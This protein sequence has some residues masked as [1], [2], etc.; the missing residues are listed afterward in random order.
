MH[1]PLAGYVTSEFSPTRRHPVT[2]KVTQHWGIDIASGTGKGTVRAAYAGRVE[3]AG[4]GKLA[5]RS[6]QGVGIRNPDGEFQFYNHLQAI[7]V[8]VGDWVTA[9][10]II[11]IEGATGNVTGP[12]LHFECHY[13]GSNKDNGYSLVRNPR[14]DFRAAGITPGKNTSTTTQTATSGKDWFAMAT[15]AQLRKIIREELK[16]VHT[17]IAGVATKV[18]QWKMPHPVSK[19]ASAA[20]THLVH[21]RANITKTNN[22]VWTGIKRLNDIARELLKK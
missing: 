19:K 14:E 3:T 16:P 13:A 17:R 1:N 5:H 22:S 4:W 20:W 9:G 21:A 18:W 6:G 11:G 12:H 2:G 15:E 10:Q 7:H 8:K